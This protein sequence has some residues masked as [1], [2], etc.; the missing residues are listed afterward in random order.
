M[1]LTALAGSAVAAG[2][3]YTPSLL[4]SRAFPQEVSAQEAARQEA[5]AQGRWEGAIQ[6]PGAELGV[7]VDL[8]VREG[9]WEGAIDIPAQGAVDR[10]L[11]GI[12]VAGDSV[13]FTI[14]GTPGEP[15]FRGALSSAGDSLA[16][17]F[18]QGGQ[19]FPFRLAR[20]GEAQLAAGR[21]SPQEALEG[22]DAFVEESM[23]R[24]NVPGLALAV[25]ADGEVVLS[26]GYGY[27]DLE[28][29][30]PV[31]ENTVMPIGSA[32]KAFTA[33]L[34]GLLVGEGRLAW[35]EP[36][37]TWLPEF[38]LRDEFASERM[39]PVDLLTHRSGLPRHDLLWY[40]ATLSREAL[41]DRLRHLEPSQPFRTTFQYNNFMFMTAGYLAGH[42]A[43]SSW[44]EQVRTRIFAPLGMSASTFSIDR[45]LAEA[46]DRALGYRAVDAGEEATGAAGGAGTGAP[47]GLAQSAEKR[48]ERM[49]YRRIDAMGPAG[50]I[51]SN[52]VD[53]IRWVRLQ[54]GN[55]TVDGEEIVPAVAVQ[56]THTPH[57]VVDEGIFSLLFRQPE[58]P[59]MM[60]GLGWF[61]QPY[62]GRRHIHHG[63]NIDGFSSLVSF[64]PDDG[65]GVV[66]LTNLNG[67]PL[68]TV[69]ALSLY[70]RLLDLEPR[71][72]NAR[73][74]EIWKRV[75][76]VQRQ[77]AEGGGIERAE[78]TSPSHPLD[79]YV[80]IYA[81]P[82]YG[83]LRIA[84]A[85]E[86]LRGVYHDFVLDLR[87]FHYDVFE[88]TFAPPLEDMKVKVEF[89]TNLRGDVDGLALPLEPAV[90]PIVFE[91]EPPESMRDP[92]FLRQFTGA[93][94]LMGLTARVLLREETGV[95]TL[96]VPG[97]PTST[98]VPY[99][100]TEF[101]IEG[102]EGASV[103][104][105]VEEGRV[106]EMVLIQPGGVLRA[107]KRE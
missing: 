65:V 84:R 40:G 8:G 68:P 60:Y 18:S 61:V 48:I 79:A 99:R 67:T 83:A 103:R 39:T 82:A 56:K 106:T 46:P 35:D 10:A 25:V 13:R 105:V 85:A 9:V 96:V 95:L 107:Q 27:R 57:V 20:T 34:V 26:R 17:E 6:L 53:M 11:S 51:N 55:G 76:A 45:M 30:E 44:E 54:L 2:K 69:L 92:A 15:T 70:D 102:M 43:G 71:D 42:V 3:P 22:W 4:A 101:E 86:G 37:R 64:L 72:W 63:G 36:V 66:I 104:F 100:G 38:E 23:A 88:G 29:R 94:D 77:Q 81:H 78:G 16:G 97:Q 5:P 74:D 80:G 52:V 47:P 12:E 31:T 33:L 21:P 1:C 24:W 50:S 7:I 91:R 32:S 62:R 19:T 90:D 75:E 59:Y 14:T 89:S 41:F 93:Y 49:E 98:L 73:Y 58:T 28:A 87:H